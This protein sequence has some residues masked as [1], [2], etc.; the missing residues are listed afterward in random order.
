VASSVAAAREL[1]GRLPL[2]RRRRWAAGR[3]AP[4]SP[5][6]AAGF[7]SP[8]GSAGS[9]LTAA[10]GASSLTAS[11]APVSP[12]AGFAAPDRPLPPRRLRR[13]R[14]ADEVV[15]VAPPP[16]PAPEVSSVAAPEVWPSP[17]AGD[18]AL[19]GDSVGAGLGCRG[20][21]GR[22][23]PAGLLATALSPCGAA[24][25]SVPSAAGREPSGESAGRLDRPRPRLRRRRRGA[26]VG[27]SPPPEGPGATSTAAA[28]SF[29]SSVTRN[30]FLLDAVPG[31]SGN[32]V[33]RNH[34]PRP[35]R[36]Q[37]VRSVPAT[38]CQPAMK[39]RVVTHGHTSS[40]SHR[41]A[42]AL[43]TRFA[44]SKRGAARHGVWPR[45]ASRRAVL[46]PSG[47]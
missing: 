10:A 30:P 38:C 42:P 5:S 2:R 28:G 8:A 17:F 36:R 21:D 1:A 46:S 4:A 13:R 40:A 44:C 31:S 11:S 37:R 41:F 14:A 47:L 20:R 29:V 23:P 6:R 24:L 3:W 32:G 39:T 26:G 19:V 45:P 7:V 35:S 25:V 12:V 27:V 43:R 22:L 18:S 15:P 34:R 33:G 16:S 9:V